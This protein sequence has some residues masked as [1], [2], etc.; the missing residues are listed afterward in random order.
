M[1]M[2]AQGSRE[3]HPSQD[4][5]SAGGRSY[6]LGSFLILN[7]QPVSAYKGKEAQGLARL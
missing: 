1:C 6:L 4:T 3:M 5:E 2:E 7:P